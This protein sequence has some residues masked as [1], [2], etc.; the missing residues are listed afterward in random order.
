MDCI[1]GIDVSGWLNAQNWYIRH[2]HTYKEVALEILFPHNITYESEGVFPLQDIAATILATEGVVNKVGPLIEEVFGGVTVEQISVSLSSVTQ[3]SPL[4]EIFF[5]SLIIGFQDDLDEEVPAFI[6]QLSGIAVPE[7]YST[8][9]TVVSLLLLIYGADYAYK[10]LTPDGESNKIKTMF[11][12]LTSDVAEKMGVEP[13]VIVGALDKKY[14]DNKNTLRSLGKSAVQFF[15]PA[16]RNRADVVAGGKRIPLD[17][18]RD[19]PSDV[20]L[21][22][23]EPPETSEH[24]MNVEIELHAQDLDRSKYGWA[25][26]IPSVSKKRIR[27]DMYPPIEPDHLWNKTM[28]RGDGILVHRRVDSGEYLPHTFHLITVHD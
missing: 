18:I 10:R 14:G 23:S 12:E 16:K 1:C 20:E 27:M 17:T 24:L 7:Q 9:V 21:D 8:M 4:K 25:C 22:E 15:S 11:D 28:V 19:I 2:V 26:V 13:Q 6:E 5:A 3:E